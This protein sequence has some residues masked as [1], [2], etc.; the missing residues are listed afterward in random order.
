MQES[1]AVAPTPKV[2]KGV[3]EPVEER[4]LAKELNALIERTLADNDGDRRST[5]AYLVDL[6]E[7]DDEMYR[8]LTKDAFS[9]AIWNR[10]RVQ[11]TQTRHAFVHQTTENHRRGIA[12]VAKQNWYDYPIYGGKFLGSATAQDLA[13]SVEHYREQAAVNTRRADF[14]YAISTFLKKGKTVKASLSVDQ[15]EDI[16][17]TTL[18]EDPADE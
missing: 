12:A 2:K 13:E 15:I 5:H 8:F 14:L 3:K 10:L 18:S 1:I 4:N 7:S 17:K 11:S 16:A 6:L 9:V